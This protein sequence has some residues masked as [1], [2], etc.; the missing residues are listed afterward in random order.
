MSI[1]LPQ[2]SKVQHVQLI[3]TFLLEVESSSTLIKKYSK[4]SYQQTD[5]HFMC[6]IFMQI[7]LGPALHFIYE[8]RKQ[9]YPFSVDWFETA[10]QYI[11][12]TGLKFKILLPQL[13][14]VWD[15]RCTSQ[16]PALVFFQ[17]SFLGYQRRGTWPLLG[18]K[19]LRPR[20]AVKFCNTREQE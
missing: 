14:E 4:Y 9:S 17:L 20:A 8:E 3:L 1:L 15:H 10:S 16:Y 12:Q 18:A 11:A 6:T 19:E 13:P 7:F 2:L 5:T